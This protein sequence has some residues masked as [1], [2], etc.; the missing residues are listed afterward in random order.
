MEN[1]AGD[2]VSR[3]APKQP[4]HAAFP[5]RSIKQAGKRAVNGQHF[6]KKYEDCLVKRSNP[7]ELAW[8]SRIWAVIIS[9]F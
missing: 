1:E 7:T 5:S 2:L 3:V 6:G 8:V 9:N 4:N